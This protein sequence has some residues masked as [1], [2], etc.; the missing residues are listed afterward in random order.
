MHCIVG[1]ACDPCLLILR[2]NFI[3]NTILQ[4]KGYY[5]MLCYLC[6]LRHLI[7]HLSCLFFGKVDFGIVWSSDIGFYRILLQVMIFHKDCHIYFECLTIL[8]SLGLKK[9]LKI[10]K[11]PSFMSY[12]NIMCHVWVVTNDSKHG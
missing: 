3:H 5:G 11:N 4:L 2:R 1:L 10:V 7:A 12:G 9:K 8:L 6:F